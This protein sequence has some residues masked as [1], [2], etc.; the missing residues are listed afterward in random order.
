VELIARNRELPRVH[1][2]AKVASTAILV[3]NVQIGERAYVDHGV[4]IE[5]SGPAVELADEVVVFAGA[6]IRS[7]GGKSRPAFPVSLGRRT[8]VSPGCVLT[9]CSVGENCYLATGA[10]LL[11]GATVGDEV[12][13]GAGAIVHA[14]TRVPA[15]GR[16]G[17]R[18]IAVPAGDGYLSTADVEQ[19]REAVGGIDFFETAFGAREADQG[20]LHAEA[21]AT[22]LEEVHGWRD[23]AALEPRRHE[24]DPPAGNESL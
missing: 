24:D 5:S 15:R 20:K 21:L 23:Q 7:V 8:L 19:A 2:R 18:H 13:V 17:M 12:R 6:V 14:T 3:G 11:Q 4:V 1:P 22:L 16:V 9:G 10:M